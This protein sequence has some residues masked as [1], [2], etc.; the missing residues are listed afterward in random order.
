MENA[1]FIK[2]RTATYIFSPD[3]CLLG[4]KGGGEGSYPQGRSDPTG[5]ASKVEPSWG[6]SQKLQRR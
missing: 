6:E 1:V 5:A 4:L 3:G 2:E